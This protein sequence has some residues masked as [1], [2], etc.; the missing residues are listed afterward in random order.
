M[1]KIYNKFG[2]R[3]DTLVEGKT[4]ADTTVV[5]AHGFGTNK[6]EGENLFVDM[7]KMLSEKFRIVCFDFSGY[8]KSSGRQEDANIRKHA[9]DLEAVLDSVRNKYKGK[10]NI[11]AHSMGTL[12]VS[13][14][15]P[16]GISKTVFTG[17][18]SGDTEKSIKNLQKRILEKGGKVDENGISEYPRTSGAMQKIGPEF[19]K[20]RRELQPMEIIRNYSQKTR[21]AL[22][23][24]LQDE[25]VGKGDFAEY[26]K[27]ESLKYF[28]VNGTHNFSKP[29]D[30]QELIKKITE[31]FST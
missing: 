13:L 31:F 24:P 23:K 2:E 3:I 26:K 10:I 22:F 6:D 7:A 25:V 4:D 28:E 21:L 18:P 16:E 17:L 1:V 12:V 20:V 14:L 15:A 19:W 11:I 30:R 27:I 9:F 8:G 29:Q 5:F